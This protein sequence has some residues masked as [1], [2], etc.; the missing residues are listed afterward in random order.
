MEYIFTFLWSMAP[1]CE[2]RCAI[3]LGMESYDLPFVGH[4]GYDLPWY[5]VLPVAVAGNLVPAL[6]W[7]TALPVL[8]RV[9]TAVPNPVGRL[10]LW[11]SD[12]LR[13]RNMDRYHRH[14]AVVLVGLV[15]IPLPLTGVWTGCLAAWALEIPFS[16]ALPPIALGAA[17]AGGVVTGL[18]AL[19]VAAAG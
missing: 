5:G 1:V 13:R 11:R 6:F 8:G 4:R 15:A 3:P 12:Q 10:L 9:V 16:K 19:G 7:L 14:G 18:T 2:L 17:I